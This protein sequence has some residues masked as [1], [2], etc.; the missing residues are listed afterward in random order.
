MNRL[1]MTGFAVITLM[2]LYLGDLAII[3]IN[4][5]EAE[6][7]PCMELKIDYSNAELNIHNYYNA[8]LRM[9]VSDAKIVLAQTLLE[10]GYFTSR[11]CLEYNNTLGLYDSRAKDFYKMSHWSESI[12]KYKIY[13]EYKKKAKENHYE[14]LK[15]IGYAEDP[16]YL[17][18]VKKIVESIN[19]GKICLEQ[20]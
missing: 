11:I 6:E 1:G 3:D 18:K 15:R 5:L 4:T 14:F 7:K 12:Y 13:I 16:A 9:N 8:L 10:T 17:N 19:K 2:V 20:E